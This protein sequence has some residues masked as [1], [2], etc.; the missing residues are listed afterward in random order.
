[1]V[2]QLKYFPPDHSLVDGLT[3]Y[4]LAAILTGWGGK[5]EYKNITLA[6]VEDPDKMH[7][8]DLYLYLIDWMITKGH[9]QSIF[10]G[11]NM[12]TK[13]FFR[14]HVACYFIECLIAEIKDKDPENDASVILDDP[15]LEGQIIDRLSSSFSVFNAVYKNIPQFRIPI[16]ESES[17]ATKYYWID[18]RIFPHRELHNKQMAIYEDI[19][20]EFK[21]KYKTQ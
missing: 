19:L 7:D 13:D 5:E 14:D 18:S 16:G 8:N 12:F 4:Q 11:Q 21:A 6:Q 2:D 9:V 20:N 3:L 15:N 17:A 10:E 1:L